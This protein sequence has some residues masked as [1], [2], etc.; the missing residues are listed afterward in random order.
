MKWL[1]SL[2]SLFLL[3][4]C[5]L[6]IDYH[7]PS[8]RFDTPEVSGVFLGGDVSVSHAAGH[9]VTLGEVYEDIIFHSGIHASAGQY[10]EKADTINLKADLGLLPRLDF[11]YRSNYDS[12]DIVGAKVQLLGSGRAAKQNGFKLAATFG[13]G[14][15]SLDD[16]ELTIVN[17]QNGTSTKITSS[18]KTRA[19]DVSLNAG[20]RFNS[21][22]IVYLNTYYTFYRI[23]GDLSA[24]DGTDYSSKG[25]SKN[26]GSLLGFRLGE[27]WYLAA[28]TGYSKG[29]YEELEQN[30]WLLGLNSG[31]AW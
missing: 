1:A 21:W 17:D 15:E 8:N 13:L 22:L 18:L 20:H 2:I 19:Y 16:D 12:T 6:D 27:N 25:N 30:I 28:E 29:S 10:I 23:N 26:Y 7:M 9:K 4:S 3:C 24:S 5:A 11:F 14:S 31:F